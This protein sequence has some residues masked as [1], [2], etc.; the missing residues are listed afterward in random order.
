MTTGSRRRF[1]ILVAE[2]EVVLLERLE[3]LVPRYVV[4]VLVVALIRKFDAEQPA[5]AVLG[6]LDG[7]VLAVAL[8][9]PLADPVV[10]GGTVLSSDG[11]SLPAVVTS[12]FS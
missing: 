1:P 12:R 4:E 10:V 2:R 7:R 9:D 6:V 8:L 5:V 3:E 11:V